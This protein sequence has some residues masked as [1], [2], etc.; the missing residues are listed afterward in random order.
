M[1]AA[2]FLLFNKWT[3]N[4]LSLPRSID[5]F[6]IEHDKIYSNIFEFL[7]QPFS[8]YQHTIPLQIMDNKNGNANIN[9]IQIV[10][11]II[12]FLNIYNI[13][14]DFVCTDGIHFYDQ[15]HYYFFFMITSKEF[16]IF[17]HLVLFINHML[18]KEFFYLIRVFYI[19]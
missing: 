14:M 6:E 15:E 19:Y 9:V 8:L 16:I 2:I 7:L 12:S 3:S 18:F 4:I 13:I 5:S 1:S 10:K 11:K 17:N